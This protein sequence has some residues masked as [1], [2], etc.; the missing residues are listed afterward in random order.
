[1]YFFNKTQNHLQIFQLKAALLIVFITIFSTSL[2]G[3]FASEAQA[4]TATTFV[5]DT[6]AT[7]TAYGQHAQEAMQAVN[8]ALAEEEAR[9]SLYDQNSDIARVN[10]QAGGAAVSVSSE[11]AQL[12]QDALELS[13]DSEGA[14]SLSLA[15]LTTAWNIAGDTPRVLEESEVESL[16]PL[17]NDSGVFVRQNSIALELEG[18]GLDLGGLAKG[19][20]CS[21]AADIYEEYEVDSALLYLGGNIY[22][23]G[24]KPGG[25][26]WRI[27]FRDP[28]GGQDSYIASFSLQDEVV[29]VSGG[30]ER[31]FEQDGERY[32]HILDPRTG[33]PAESDLLSVGV[34]HENGLEAD[35]TSTTLYVQGLRGALSYMQEGGLAIALDKTGN[36]YVSK[37][38][39]AD[40]SLQSPGSH[41]LHFVEVS[42]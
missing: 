1:M 23:R 22:A 4:Q 15:P 10:T 32:I 40:F 21:V 27:G 2:S 12:V 3:C 11:T 24:T 14:F 7:Q 26:P 8:R 6:L 41:T 35:I 33:Y 29:A 34:L 18:M 19:A 31:Y 30:Y 28:E 25:E 5:M 17:V 38:L 37:A 16:L 9:L 42:A 13:L 39:E 36:L 20:A